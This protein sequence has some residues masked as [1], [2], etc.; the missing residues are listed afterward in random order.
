MMK[1]VTIVCVIA[2]GLAVV[3]VAEPAIARSSRYC[4]N[5][6]TSGGWLRATS[7]VSCG[8]A[9]HVM[10]HIARRCRNQV[11][12]FEGFRCIMNPRDMGVG[13]GSCTASRQRGIRW[14]IP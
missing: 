1:R 12:Y 6:A 11:C 8:T 7:N 9:R 13:P 3:A 10:T 5:D 2:L 14:N 4:F